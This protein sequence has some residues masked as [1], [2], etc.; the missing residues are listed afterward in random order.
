MSDMSER[1]EELGEILTPW[2]F[3]PSQEHIEVGDSLKALNM[4]KEKFGGDGKVSLYIIKLANLS[5]T[6]LMVWHYMVDEMSILQPVFSVDDITTLNHSIIKSIKQVVTDAYYYLGNILYSAI[7]T[8]NGNIVIKKVRSVLSEADMHNILQMRGTEYTDIYPVDI[9]SYKHKKFIGACWAIENSEKRII[10]FEP[11]CRDENK[12]LTSVDIDD[13]EPIPIEL[14]GEVDI[15]GDTFILRYK[16]NIGKYFEKTL[17]KQKIRE[18]IMA[19]ALSL[20]KKSTPAIAQ[21]PP[22][23]T[24]QSTQLELVESYCDI[25]APKV[26]RGKILNVDFKKWH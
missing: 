9:Y 18:L 22:K 6:E 2:E 19:K 21:E 8:T 20:S 14:N 5:S 7:H 25:S 12:K 10:H 4:F 26:K 23:E 11:I 3:S 16:Q 24:P 17:S 13:I 15:G 1:K